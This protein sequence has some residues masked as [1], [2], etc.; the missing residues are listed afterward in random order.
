MIANKLISWFSGVKLHDYGCTLKAYRKEVLDGVRLYGEMHRFIP[1][2]AHMHGGKVTELAVNHR[3]RKFGKSKYGLERIFKVLLDLILVK[4][5]ASYTAKPMYVFGGF[6][7]ICLLLSLFPI[8]L[9]VFYKL[10]PKEWGQT[11]H[12]D[13][14]ET[15]LPVIAVA[16]VLVGF[17]ALLQGILAEMLMRTYFES[18]GKRPYL[19]R[20]AKVKN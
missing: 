10:M 7:L 6:G 1:I 15:P 13:F 4:F 2:Y 11:W 3:A 14:V 5:L 18:Q 20:E 8:G 19:L 17:L 12:K 16:M 9:A